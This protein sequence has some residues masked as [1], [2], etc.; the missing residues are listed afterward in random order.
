MQLFEEIKARVSMRELLEHYNI[1][2]TRGTNIYK[3]PF[4]DDRRPSASIIR[5]CDKFNCF[6]CGWHGDIFDVVQHFE[7]CDHKTAMKI[8]DEKFGLGI[9]GKLS[10]EQK[11]EMVKNQERRNQEKQA[12]KEKEKLLRKI[13]ITLRKDLAFWSW[14]EKET[15]PRLREFYNN[16]WKKDELFFYAIK[17]ESRLLWLLDAITSKEIEP[18]EYSAIYGDTAEKIIEKLKKELIFDEKNLKRIDSAVDCWHHILSGNF[19]V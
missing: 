12:L 9:L 1:Y 6:A 19:C 18:C 3:C 14:V 5:V 8:I 16:S 11:L 4:H 2:P 7:K 15:E 13:S 10:R 17:E